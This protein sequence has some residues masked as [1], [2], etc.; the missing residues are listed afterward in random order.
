[1]QPVMEFGIEKCSLLIVKSGKRETAIGIIIPNQENFWS[2]GEKVK[3]KFLGILEA[4][5]KQPEIKETK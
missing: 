2:L 5:I 4:I 3:Y 1:M